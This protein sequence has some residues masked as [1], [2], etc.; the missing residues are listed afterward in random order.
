MIIL[1]RIFI[2]FSISFNL[3]LGCLDGDLRE[4]AHLQRLLW[5]QHLRSTS[6]RPT[7]LAVFWGSWRHFA[8]S[9]RKDQP[10]YSIHTYPF[11]SYKYHQLLVT[12]C[13]YII[14]NYIYDWN[15]LQRCSVNR[16]TMPNAV[17]LFEGSYRLIDSRYIDGY[18][19]HRYYM[20]YK[21]RWSYVHRSIDLDRLESMHAHAPMNSTATAYIWHHN[22]R[23]VSG[24]LLMLDR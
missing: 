24:A 22:R 19:I 13:N 14:R 4:A 16:S 18:M 7:R 12:S 20:I 9:Q 21:H 5:R 1:H 23:F 15:G 2:E 10:T 3:K 8:S 6:Q 11:I 17:W